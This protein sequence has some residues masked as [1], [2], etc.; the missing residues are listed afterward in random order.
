MI[1]RNLIYILQ[2]ENY[3]FL[4]FL[5]FVY[6][7]FE[8][9]G[10]QKRQ[11]IKWTFKARLI[12]VGTWAISIVLFFNAVYF[13]DWLG[14]FS[15]SIILPLLPLI[16]GL[17][18]LALMPFEIILKKII[19]A[20]AKRIISR[21]DL[22]KI[23]ITGS[24]G[25][26]STKEIL[27][28]IL[29]KKFSVIKTPENINTE[30]GIAQFIIS[31]QAT[32]SGANVFVVEMGAYVV[33]DIKKICKMVSPDHSILT[34]INESHLER[35]GKIQNTIKTKFELPESTKKISVLNFDDRNV[36]ENH[37][38]FKIKNVVGIST[39]NMK[40]IIKKENFG[41]IGF[42]YEDAS[43]ETKLLAE[44]NI[45]LIMMCC[46]IAMELGVDISEIRQAVE[47]IK[48]VAHRLE[49]IYNKATDVMVIDDS[50]NGNFDGIKSGI[51]VLSR[52][53][54]RKIVLTP[55][56]VELGNASKEV[57]NKIG[58]LYAKSVDL[59]LLIK[60]PMTDDIMEGM[61]KNNF[62]NFVVYENTNEAHGDLGKILKS[63]DTIIFQNDLTDNYF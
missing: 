7:N 47:E 18:L 54:G 21:S 6:R 4:R 44:H 34:G 16:I 46:K 17:M 62:N 43:L 3:D 11:E 37:S 29:E 5:K 63:G 26:T 35:F 9:W 51:E 20:K 60:S 8:W 59:V 56:L 52:A 19:V 45:A 38:K 39:E 2:S 27:S 30:L 42:E 25:K 33:G 10:L 14:I 40:G 41:G 1:I 61:R 58:E 53:N 15:I 12:Q 13:F 48:P 57:H 31:N 23:G 49:P 22:I 24:Y 28:Q 50:Y 36:L 55:G 32:L